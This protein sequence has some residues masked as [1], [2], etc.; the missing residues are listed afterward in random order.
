MDNSKKQYIK[1]TLSKM[2][3]KEV[4][5][6]SDLKKLPSAVNASVNP[7]RFGKISS[8]SSTDAQNKST[9]SP[10]QIVKD[11]A[12]SILRKSIDT[13]IDG[14]K[15]AGRLFSGPEGVSGGSLTSQNPDDYNPNIYH[16]SEEEDKEYQPPELKAMKKKWAQNK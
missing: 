7:N 2:P 6:M 11:G 1:N 9:P 14:S 12:K 5:K 13:V 16:G 4:P 3:K 8:L 10:F 15:K